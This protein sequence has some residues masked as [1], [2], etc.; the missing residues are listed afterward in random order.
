MFQSVHSFGLLPQTFLPLDLRVKKTR[1]LRRALTKEQ[2]RLRISSR[3]VWAVH[4][5]LD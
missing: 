4:V 1:A 5:V 2:V 3:A